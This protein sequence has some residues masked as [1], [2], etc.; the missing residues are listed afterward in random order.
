MS[1]EP[2]RTLVHTDEGDLPFQH[3]FVRRRCEP[4]VLDTYVG[5]AEARL[6]HLS[7]RR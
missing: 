6:T 1:D 3:Y 2:V 7:T 4:C 5:A